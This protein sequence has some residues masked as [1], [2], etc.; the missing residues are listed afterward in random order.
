MKKNNSESMKINMY[1]YSKY[2]KLLSDTAEKIGLNKEALYKL[3]GGFFDKTVTGTIKL[4]IVKKKIPDKYLPVIK[5]IILAGDSYK[6]YFNL[7]HPFYNHTIN[8]KNHSELILEKIKENKE[9]KYW[10]KWVN[11]YENRNIEERLAKKSKT[12]FENEYNNLSSKENFETLHY[13]IF[14]EYKKMKSRNEKLFLQIEKRIKLFEAFYQIFFLADYASWIR[15]IENR[16]FG[17]ADQKLKMECYSKAETILDKLRK[18]ILE[19]ENP[20]LKKQFRLLELRVY[21]S[22]GLS[23]FNATQFKE[24]NS[25]DRENAIIKSEECLNK[26]SPKTEDEPL[27]KIEYQY[28]KFLH[29]FKLIED[30]ILLKKFYEIKELIELGKSMLYKLI[31]ENRVVIPKIQLKCIYH[32][33]TL[34]YYELTIEAFIREQDFGEE[35]ANYNWHIENRKHYDGYFIKDMDFITQN[36]LKS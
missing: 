35:N 8:K 16:G 12:Y 11:L 25:T 36:L 9:D 7:I 29:H 28:L 20:D 4:N 31:Q 19:E 10:S 34:N 21:G 32:L 27:Y 2:Y 13:E 18:F 15:D 1:N 22:I 17:I 5:Y 24:L 26:I 3:I 33:R 6:E 30:H 23:N 14:P